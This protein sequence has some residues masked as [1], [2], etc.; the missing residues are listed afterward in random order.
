MSAEEA[1]VEWHTVLLKVSELLSIKFHNPAPN[2]PQPT[3]IKISVHLS[4]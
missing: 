2:F 1:R 3:S 4:L